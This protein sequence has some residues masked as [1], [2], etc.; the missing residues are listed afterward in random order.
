MAKLKVSAASIAV[1]LAV[2]LACSTFCFDAHVCMVGHMDHP[3]YTIREY[4][5]DALWVASLIL[6]LIF[7]ARIRSHAS[8]ASALLTG[9]VLSYRFVFGSFG[10][11]L[12][13]PL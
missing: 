11:I 4:A 1:L 3:P 10:G 5:G 2:A 6:S 12:G 9:F 13:I 8:L 7:L